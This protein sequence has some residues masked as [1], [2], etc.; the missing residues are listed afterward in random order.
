MCQLYVFSHPS[1]GRFWQKHVSRSHPKSHSPNLTH[2]DVLSPGIKNQAA[3]QCLPMM[4]PAD[5]W[6]NLS[7]WSIHQPF[8]V[9]KNRFHNPKLPSAKPCCHRSQKNIS[10]RISL[11]WS[12]SRVFNNFLG[13]TNLPII[14]SNPTKMLHHD[15]ITKK[16]QPFK[17]NCHR[18]SAFQLNPHNQKSR[19]C[20]HRS[21]VH[22]T[23]LETLWEVPSSKTSWHVL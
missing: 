8:T 4:L 20:L 12:T 1:R 17:C 5:I 14:G 23:T 18:F 10:T 3:R 16:A 15:K 7:G 6:K 2:V 9:M 19:L 11:K 21:T 13:S 22:E